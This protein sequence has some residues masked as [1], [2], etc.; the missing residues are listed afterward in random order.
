MKKYLALLLGMTS[1]LITSSV[2][3]AETKT[4]TVNVSVTIAPLLELSVSGPAG[5]N[6][7]FGLTNKDPNG[8]VTVNSEDVVISATTN[9]RRP[10]QI[11]Q[12]L[13]TPLENEH[14]DV[15]S[16]EDFSVSGKSVSS[17]GTVLQGNVST[18][19]TVLFRSD[20][21]GMSDT[22]VTKYHLNVKPEQAPGRYQSRLIYT[23]TTL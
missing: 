19:P 6:I 15:F 11:T 13:V 16:S 8:A 7:E 5:G 4:H 18:S 14:N 3:F 20:A 17:K 22:F 12:S 9:L 23:I 1:F 2:C 21:E 10:Y